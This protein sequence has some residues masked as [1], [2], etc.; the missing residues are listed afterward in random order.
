MNN[1]ME[2]AIRPV[3]MP[4]ILTENERVLIRLMMNVRIRTMITCDVMG[5]ERCDSVYIVSFDLERSAIFSFLR[6][7]D[8]IIIQLHLYSKKDG[9]ERER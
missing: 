9:A 2:I 4:T 6:T 8:E 7:M 1:A 3:R 5:F